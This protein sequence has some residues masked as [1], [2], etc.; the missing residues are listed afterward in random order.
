M[1]VCQWLL[2]WQATED[3]GSEGGVK[4]GTGSPLLP[5]SALAHLNS[6]GSPLAGQWRNPTV[7][8]FLLVAIEREEKEEAISWN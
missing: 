3:E 1:A 6:I 5:A 4:R 8:F 7:S 2:W